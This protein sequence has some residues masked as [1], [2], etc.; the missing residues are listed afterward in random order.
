MFYHVAFRI[1]LI[2][3]AIVIKSVSINRIH[4]RTFQRC[5]CK[6]THNGDRKLPSYY[7][8]LL[9][10]AY[11][12]KIQ[13]TISELSI[14]SASK[15]VFVRNH[16]YEN[17]FHLQV[18]FH[19]NQTHFHMKSFARRL[20]LRQRQ[21]RTRKWPIHSSFVAFFSQLAP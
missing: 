18:H 5:S 15:R 12:L 8:V 10:K 19:A 20:V 14:A 6:V 3:Y 1:T 9:A 4:V 11:Q 13:Q 21:P 17:V 7:R 16:S 2:G